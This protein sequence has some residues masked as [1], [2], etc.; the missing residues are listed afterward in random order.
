VT[1]IWARIGNLLREIG[2]GG[3]NLLDRIMVAI[4]GDEAH[5]RAVAFSIAVVALS[6][7]MARAD[8]VVTADEVAAFR[9]YFEVPPGEEENVRR[10]FRLAQADI[11]GYQHYARRIAELFDDEPAV[12]E[13]VLEGLFLIAAADGYV[14]ESELAF[15]DSVAGILGVDAVAFARIKASHVHDPG[16]PYV[17][18]GIERGASEAVLRA[19]YR[20]LVRDYHPDRFVARGLPPEFV[21]I[22]NDRLAAINAAW[23]AIEKERG[24]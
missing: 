7:K 19:H 4:A 11:A 21:K 24:W 23:N 18:L 14:H 10:L 12:R 22:A 15:L 17:V 6:A 13:D 20:A 5:R 9:A 16:D 1:S 8:G 3:A 2:T